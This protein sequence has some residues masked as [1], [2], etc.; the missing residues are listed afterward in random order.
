M[1][2]ARVDKAER[3]CLNLTIVDCKLLT[4]EEAG[5]CIMSLNLTIVDCKLLIPL[6]DLAGAKS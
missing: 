5:G 2:K 1:N 4:S 3:V 6:P